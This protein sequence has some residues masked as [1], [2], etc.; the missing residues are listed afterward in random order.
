MNNKIS[1][2]LALLLF[3]CLS[4]NQKRDESKKSSPELSLNEQA[5]NLAKKFIIT[6]GHIDLPYH[7][8]SMG[9]LDLKSTPDLVTGIEGNFDF[10]RAKE[11]GLDAPFMSIY[12]PAGLQKTGGSKELAD[13]LINMVENICTKFPDHFAI[14][15]SPNDVIKNFAAGKISLPMGMENGSPIE[16][17]L[18]NVAYFYDRG[19]RYITLTHGKVNLICDSSYDPER[20]WNG[21]SPFGKEVVLEMNKQGIMVDVSHIS[22]ST[23]YDVMEITDVPCIASH[24]SARKFTPGF[25]RNMS[26][27]MIK[28]LAKKNGVIQIN[29]GSSFLTH[30][31]EDK[32]AERDSLKKVYMA[33]NNLTG[34]DS[35]T[36]AFHDK[37]MKEN[38][39]YADVNAVADHIDHVVKIAGIDYVGLGSDYD[40]VGDS[41]PTGLKDVAGFP[42]LIEELLKRGYS[43]DDIEK[44]CSGN[45]FRVWNAVLDHAGKNN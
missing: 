8:K 28:L 18:E 27:D 3:F 32:L 14:V 21:L 2:S 34:K 31:Y 42:N 45:V 12:I 13:S 35:L 36:K 41:L 44:I 25:E 9:F 6:D 29:F 33:E 17:N 37:W 26:D 40:G 23:F 30:T 24:S 39:P 7:L 43:E 5:K 1:I 15:S 38:D 10:P 4:C 16:D 20:K 22:D 19:I 11:G